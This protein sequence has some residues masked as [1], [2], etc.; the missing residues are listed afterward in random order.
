[1]ELYKEKKQSDTVIGMDQPINPSILLAI[2]KQQGLI[3]DRYQRDIYPVYAYGDRRRRPIVWI[4]RLDVDRL[5]ASGQ[6][7]RVSRGLSLK[8]DIERRILKGD[9]LSTKYKHPSDG[10]DKCLYVPAGV[11]RQVKVMS[12]H[13][14]LRRLAR[15][16]EPD[17]RPVLSSAEIEAGHLFQRDYNRAFNHGYITQSLQSVKV[18]KTLSNN[19]EDNAVMSLDSAK[20]YNR[21]KDILGPG[22][23][24]AAHIICGEGKSLETLEREQFWS[25][26][27][28][29][30][31]LKLALS[32]LAEYYGTSPGHS[33]RDYAKNNYS[34]TDQAQAY[35]SETYH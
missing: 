29:K 10:E 8:Y 31:I 13:D 18:D 32:R 7:K 35:S 2:A 27:S 6:L 1:M 9:Y 34:E 25:R 23:S 14:I 28:G 21:A 22:L 16:K 15:E 4:S 3:D 5:Y 30:T 17:G 11:K 24:D 20:A 33:K 26:N 12:D 19:V